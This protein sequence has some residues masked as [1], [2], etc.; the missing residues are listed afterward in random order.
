MSTSTLSPIATTVSSSPSRPSATLYVFTFVATV[1][2]LLLLCAGFL[3]RNYMYRRRLRSHLLSLNISTEDREEIQRANSAQLRAIAN[4][5]NSSGLTSDGLDSR[6]FLGMPNTLFVPNQRRRATKEISLGR[7]P[8]LWEV[9]TGEDQL[10][11]RINTAAFDWK[12]LCPISLFI[13]IEPIKPPFKRPVPVLIPSQMPSVLQN[14]FSIHP[15][16]E[17]TNPTGVAAPVDSSISVLSVQDRV[18]ADL[19]SRTIYLSVFIK[20]PEDTQLISA[21]AVEQ[22][23]ELNE[24][25]DEGGLR[26]IGDVELGVAMVR[27]E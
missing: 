10:N 20:M 6:S 24:D 23:S 21:R 4:L 1:A 19:P 11:M 13:P 12:H 3:T 17:L 22:E 27:I 25:E 15:T 8:D 18:L 9:T 14:L 7:T 2:I 26:E 5:L 16:P